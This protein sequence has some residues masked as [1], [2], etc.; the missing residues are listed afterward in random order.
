[1]LDALVEPEDKVERIAF[2]AVYLDR[3]RSR[4]PVRVTVGE[5]R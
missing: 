4:P 3:L 1:M 2:Q 5:W